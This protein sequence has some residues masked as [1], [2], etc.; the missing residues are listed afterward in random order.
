MRVE[1]ALVQN[2]LTAAGFILALLVFVTSGL[3]ALVAL[4]AQVHPP[5][6]PATPAVRMSAGADASVDPQWD[7]R[8]SR[9][10]FVAAFPWIYITTLVPVCI[11]FLLA[12]AALMLLLQSQAIN[13]P[14]LFYL[15]ELLLYPALAQFLAS[16]V[17]NI[18]SGLSGAS[19]AHNLHL[20]VSVVLT[21]PLRAVSLVLWWLLLFVAPVIRIRTADLRRTGPLGLSYAAIL[22]AVMLV[23]ALAYQERHS[24]VP[25]LCALA[26]QVF[27]PCYW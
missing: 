10:E 26:V 19:A 18:V 2:R 3:I 1:A 5:E 27:Q 20:P 13:S 6:A 8:T 7:S 12:L 21:H 25:L 23:S 24:D 22:V 14:F 9:A 15:G 4:R 11:G 17:N 16:G